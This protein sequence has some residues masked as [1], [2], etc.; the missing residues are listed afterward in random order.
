MKRRYGFVSN[1]SS[2]S[3]ICEVC[4]EEICGM[5]ICFEDW[6]FCEC[7]EEHVFCQEHIIGEYDGSMYEVPESQCPICQFTDVALSDIKKYVLL[8]SGFNSYT[9]AE[10]AIKEEFDSYSALV[11]YLYKKNKLG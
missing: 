7:V 5:D 8:K 4:G 6:G 2:S 11:N 9:E 10:E 1:S 3:F